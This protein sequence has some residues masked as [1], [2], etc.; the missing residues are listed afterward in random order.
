VPDD[1]CRE[2]DVDGE[3][4]RVHGGKQLDD[5]GQAALGEVVRAARERL[6]EVDPNYAI[7]QELIMA[8]LAAM[9]AIPDGEVRGRCTVQDGAK[10]KARLKAAIAAARGALKSEAPGA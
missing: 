6:A 7:A 10:V 4:V 1:S 2:Y 5:A 9:R 8:G 3:P